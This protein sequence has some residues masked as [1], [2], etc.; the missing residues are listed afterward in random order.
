[1]S[2]AEMQTIL[3]SISELKTEF[4]DMQGDIKKVR[5]GQA[6]MGADLDE[7]RSQ[8]NKIETRLDNLCKGK[9]G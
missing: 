8:V 7:L 2:N 4:F 1:M 3:D 6:K 9:N 5:A